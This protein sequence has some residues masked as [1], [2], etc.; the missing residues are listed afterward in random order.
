VFVLALGA[1]AVTFVRGDIA[2]ILRDLNVKKDKT[3]ILSVDTNVSI[4]YEQF[5]GAIYGFP[6]APNIW[7]IASRITNN[8]STPIEIQ[9]IYLYSEARQSHSGTVEN[10]NTICP[11][12]YAHE[13]DPAKEG[14]PYGLT[15]APN[16]LSGEVQKEVPLPMHQLDAPQSAGDMVRSSGVIVGAVHTYAAELTLDDKPVGWEKIK[17]SPHSTFNAAWAFPSSWAA[18]DGVRSDPAFEMMHLGP[19][20]RISASDPTETY[21]V[22]T[23][24]NYVVGGWMKQSSFQVVKITP[25]L[26]GDLAN[27]FLDNHSSVEKFA[28]AVLRIASEP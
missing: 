27:P 19:I 23:R 1:I 17:L 6:S 24:L 14:L 15:I 7:H 13:F 4:Q 20:I 28:S 2:R 25:T 21:L 12:S 3:P 18:P 11:R 5:N 10:S 8:G 22:V 26:P 9:P 16:D